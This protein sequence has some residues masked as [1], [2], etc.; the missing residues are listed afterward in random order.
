MSTGTISTG[1]GG[2]LSCVVVTPEKTLFDEV[3]E[4]VALPV[5]D[6]ELGV[7]PGRTPVIARLGYGEL[8]TRVGSTTKRY[9]IDGGF[10]QIRDNVVTVLTGRA[11]P[12][13]QVSASAAETELVTAQAR[14]ATT[15]FQ[16]AEK[17][18]AIARARALLRV[19][20]H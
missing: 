12:A 17:T 11:I 1:T 6:G 2:Q 4:F 14:K 15:D 19:A 9:F 8:R 13:S 16:Q 3:V 20:S 5:F 18:K 7:L 10:A